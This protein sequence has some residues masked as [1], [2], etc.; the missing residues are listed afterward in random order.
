MVF[1]REQRGELDAA[2]NLTEFRFRKEI[3]TAAPS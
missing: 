3:A 1:T 2:G